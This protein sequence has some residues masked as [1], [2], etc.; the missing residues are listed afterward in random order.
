MADSISRAVLFKFASGLARPMGPERLAKY[1]DHDRAVTNHALAGMEERIL[2]AGNDFG[3]GRQHSGDGVEAALF[4]RIHCLR[5]LFTTSVALT[6]LPASTPL[7]NAAVKIFGRILLIGWPALLLDGLMVVEFPNAAWNRAAAG[8]LLVSLPVFIFLTL[9]FCAL[10]T[11]RLI[12]RSARR[13]TQLPTAQPLS[14]ITNS[15]VPRSHSIMLGLLGVLAMAAFVASLL[16][17]IEHTFKS[18]TVYRISL[19]TARASPEVLGMLGNPVD[20][21]WFVSGE[22]SESYNG[23]G[24]ATLTIPLRG[25]RGRG[26]LYVQAGRQAGTW[27]FSVLQFQPDG[28]DSKVDLLDERPR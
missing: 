1:P 18:S 6:I 23:A 10:A 26:R 16:L 19:A 27:R 22:L 11:I 15:R 2:T 8:V 24:S 21:R 4:I 7:M 17:S 20:V 13:S 14:R 12:S 25:P 9:G 5:S 28:H 3:E